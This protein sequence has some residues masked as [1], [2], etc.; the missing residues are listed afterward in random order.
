M[1]VTKR[2]RIQVY[3]SLVCPSDSSDSAKIFNQ[4]KGKPLSTGKLTVCYGKSPSLSSV[5]QLPSGNQTWQGKMNHVSVFFLFKPPF[6][7]E[8][9][10]PCLITRGPVV[11][12]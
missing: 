10:L 9:P 3:S 2:M 5:N 7:G 8:F 6:L 4:G 11:F 12:L 1:F